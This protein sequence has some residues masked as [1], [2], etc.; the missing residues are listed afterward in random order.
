MSTSIKVY[1]DDVLLF[2]VDRCNQPGRI[3]FYTYSQHN[4]T[5][6]NFY[7]QSSADIFPSADQICDGDTLFA[8]I[9]DP[10]CPDYV[11]AIESWQWNWGDG[12]STA[13]QAEAFHVYPSAG[14]YTMEL[15]AN[16]PGNCSDTVSTII[17]VQNLPEANLGPDTT[18]NA[19]ESVTLGTGGNHPG[20]T[21][22]WSTGSQLP[23]ITLLN[24][25]K[26]TTISLLVSGLLCQNYDEINIKVIHE[27][28][29][30]VPPFNI[31]VPNAFSPDGDGLNDVFIPVLSDELT[32][33]Y[34][35]YIY[36]KWGTQIF[37]SSEPGSGW[38]G[39]Y[40][41]KACQGEVYA[42][43]IRYQPPAQQQTNAMSIV[44]GCFLL[45][46]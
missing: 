31:W 36:D 42:F 39:T 5:F 27:V 43:L 45:L 35:L 20:W 30:P 22:L 3:G 19:G 23:Q 6:S 2:D 29:P 34:E 13:N 37:R 17:T 14:A 26:D 28:I 38:D 41:G 44:K 4:V 9:T 46:R 12:T 24:L 15:I 11:P 33:G 25:E 16:F 10:S 8:S 32:G 7:Y 21:Y 40:K 1:V 18:I